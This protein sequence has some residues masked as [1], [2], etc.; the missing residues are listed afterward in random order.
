[1][2]AAKY[3][4][5]YPPELNDYVLITDKTYTRE[6]ILQ[7]EYEILSQLNFEITFQLPKPVQ[8]YG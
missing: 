4:E 3:E 8:K 6:N 1:M 5:I 7:M 2:I